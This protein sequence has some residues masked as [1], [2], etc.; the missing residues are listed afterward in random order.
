HERVQAV[1]DDAV[2]TRHAGLAQY[3]NELL[4]NRAHYGLLCRAGRGPTKSLRFRC[5]RPGDSDAPASREAAG[6]MARG[7]A[8]PP[9]AVSTPSVGQPRRATRGRPRASQSRFEP[10]QG[11]VKK[12]ELT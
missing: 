8:T 6:R 2:H 1:A 4:T 7:R 11:A 12:E 3:V 10:A 9:V 5:R